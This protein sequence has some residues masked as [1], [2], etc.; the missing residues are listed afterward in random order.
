MK[1]TQVVVIGGGQA[2][3]A[4]SHC[5]DRHGI[6]HVVLER[7]RIGERWRGERWDSLRLLTPNWMSRLPGFSYRGSDPDGYMTMPEVVRYLEDYA[8][9]SAAPV[10]DATTVRSV[11][12]LPDGYRPNGYRPDGYRVETNRGTWMA[13]AVVIAT[14]HCDVPLVPAMARHL[15]ADIRQVTP[16]RY[17][18][19]DDLP[20]GGVLVVGASATGAQLADELHRSGR[21]VTLSVGRHTRLPRL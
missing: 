18:N 14:G 13:R 7:G 15:P 21:P 16:S 9:H 19:P 12:R 11:E 10:E 17:R 2:G 4:M 5:L 1:R 8:R 6:D 20:D 3:L